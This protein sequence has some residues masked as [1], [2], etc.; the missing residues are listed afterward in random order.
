MDLTSIHP[1]KKIKNSFTNNFTFKISQN[2]KS[3]NTS[4]SIM[5]G[6]VRCRK[7]KEISLFTA[8]LG[9]QEVPV[10]WS[11][12]WWKNK[13][14]PTIKHLTRSKQE[15]SGPTPI[16]VSDCNSYSI[17]SS[18]VILNL[19]RNMCLTIDSITC[20]IYDKIIKIRARAG[21]V[22]ARPQALAQLKSQK[23]DQKQID[24][25]LF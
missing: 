19:L 7:K 3:N 10:L 8:Q 15:G 5:S 12:F 1:S 4:Q 21:T 14:C 24:H 17:T 20:N 2:K 13:N 18:W 25:P 6:W 16:Q 9:F 22:T 23:E 11:P